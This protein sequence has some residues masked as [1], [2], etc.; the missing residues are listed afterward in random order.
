MIARNSLFQGEFSLSVAL[1]EEF[2]IDQDPGPVP[3]IEKVKLMQHKPYWISQ[4]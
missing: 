2:D 3:A 1:Y 4:L